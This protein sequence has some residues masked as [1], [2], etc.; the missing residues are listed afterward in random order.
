MIISVVYLLVRCL[1]G[2]LMVLTRHQVSKD[3]ELLVLRHETAVLRRQISRVRYQ[4]GDRLWL[5]ALSRLVP[6][7]RWGQVFTVTPATLLAWHRRLVA[8][9]WDYT[10]RRRPGR[11]SSAWKRPDLRPPRSR[12]RACHRPPGRAARGG[13]RLSPGSPN[14][15]VAAAAASLRSRSSYARPGEGTRV[16]D[17]RR[18]SS[19]CLS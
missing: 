15:V 6:R 1:L 9:K 3:A 10:S 19:S 8:R 16:P 2:C 13:W 7:R 17:S 5:A 18:L 4:P 14:L 11:P 12:P